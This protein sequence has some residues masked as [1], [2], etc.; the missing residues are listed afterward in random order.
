[1]E[2]YQAFGLTVASEWELFQLQPCEKPERVDLTI[3]EGEV[4]R[5]EL[6]KATQKNGGH[7]QAIEN[8]F[9]FRIENLANF[10]L[11]DGDSITVEVA[12]GADIQ[13]VNLYLLGSAM[14]VILHQRNHGVLHGNAIRFGDSAVVVVAH[15]GVGKSTLAGEFFRLGYELLA[16]DVCAISPQGY[17]QP[18]YP[19]LKLWQNSLDKLDYSNA[20]LELIRG[21]REKYYF[22]IGEQY[23]Q[24][25]LPLA[26]I[27]ILNKHNGAKIVTRT[28]RGKRKLTPL[29]NHTYRKEY[30]YAILGRHAFASRLLNMAATTSVSRIVRPD[31]GFEL[32]ALA[33][34]IIDDF[35]H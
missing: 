22:P 32:T 9:L 7:Y 30:A 33:E 10:L 27:Y 23:Y 15:S 31:D 19:Y 4:S 16:D 13:T 17:V 12:P 8:Q 14:G 25:P 18:S 34:T 28:I 29:F 24:E 2:F 1:M 3:R 20:S 26:Q 11:S 21:Q 6:F 35:E 5:H